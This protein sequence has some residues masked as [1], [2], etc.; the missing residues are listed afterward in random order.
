V[1][2]VVACWLVLFGPSLAV[3][4]VN[5]ANPLLFNDDVRQQ[6]WPFFRYSDGGF[7]RDYIGGYYLHAFLPAGYRAVFAA[8]AHVVDPVTTSKVVP[9]CLFAL[10]LALCAL[11]ARRLQGTARILRLR[12][13]V[14][15]V[16]NPLA[17][18]DG[19]GPS[20]RFRLSDRSARDVRAG[21]GQCVWWVP[22]RS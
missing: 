19:R 12:V 5:S 6:V 22:R 9:Y 1:L 13:A 14:P 15:V 11:A 8:V 17:R 7:T 21:R 10:T 18:A 20:A 16:R 2:L 4:V 3:H